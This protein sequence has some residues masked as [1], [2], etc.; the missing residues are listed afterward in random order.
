M[1]DSGREWIVPDALSRGDLLYRDVVYW[2]G[3]LTPYFQAAFFHFFGSGFGTL[4][5]SGAVA[6]AASL[7]ALFVAA[8]GVTG[9]REAALWTALAL[10]ALCFMPNAGGSLLGMGFRIWHAAVFALLA[11]AVAARARPSATRLSA[12]GALAG[13]SGLCRTEWG[14]AAAAAV[15]LAAWR[16]SPGHRRFLRDAAA[17]V[18]SFVAVLGGGLAG[19]LLAAGK[20]AVLRDGHLLLGR[21]P[22]ETRTFLF[23]FSGLAD[24]RRGLFELT[25][26]GATW[27]G[28]F[29]LIEVRALRGREPPGKRGRIGALAGLLALLAVSALLGGAAGAVV[30]SAAP[31]VCAAA[32]VVGLRRRPGPRGAALSALGLLG[33]LLSYRR[34]FHI[35]D[36]AYV[37]PPLMFAFAC[38]AGLLRLRVT[39]L[40]EGQ[41]RRRLGNAF[42]AALLAAIGAAF[43][44]RLAHYASLE[45]EPIAGTSRMLTARPEVAREIEALA[46]AIRRGT[47]GRTGLV[48]FPEGELLNFLSGQ[49]NPIRHKLYLPGYLTSENEGEIQRELASARP[50]AV[51]LWLRPTSEYGRGLF[52]V[53]YG[54]RLRAWIDRNY[55]LSSYRAPGAPARAN[56]R[57][58]YGFRRAD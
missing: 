53:D 58:L 57:F 4:V 15:L 3:P 34:P 21:L 7:A 42:A 50:A 25:Y 14:L 49:P 51:V 19:F 52:G 8:S 11:V 2:F 13:L 48:V 44:A 9:R 35:G 43:A 41:T 12:A 37:G 1:I 28:A 17:G 22:E 26:S 38:A 16:S 47:T 45:G 55:D 29:L 18:G 46:L 39:R 32:L 33:L 54:R 30:W 5:A 20:D 56:A 40:A 27:V 23:A 31:A 36:S 6:T 24:W 10:P